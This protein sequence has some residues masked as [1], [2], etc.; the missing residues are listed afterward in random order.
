MSTLTSEL[1]LVQAQTTDDT[2]DYLTLTNGLAG[3]LAILD[4][5]FNSGSGHAHGGS[6]QGGALNPATV[7]ANNTL[8]GAK[9]VDGSVT[10]AKLAANMLESLFT[11]TMVNQGTNYTVAGGILFVFCTAA[12]TVTLP[13]ASSTNRPITVV[14]VTGAST[15]ASAG[16][17]VIGGS[18]NT[19]TGAVMNGTLSQ[20][21]SLT[22]KSD[23][24]NWRVV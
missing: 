22:F 23:G 3:S 8:P 19:S 5:L 13:A 7:F 14:G 17:S 11:S 9:L 21:D 18:I 12:I 6:H 2:S 10:Y 24:T 1:N 16:G 4:G 20:G 15:I